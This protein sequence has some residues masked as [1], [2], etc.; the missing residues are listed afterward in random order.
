M[1]KD[2]LGQNA[3]VLAFPLMSAIISVAFFQMGG[4]FSLLFL[5][6]LGAF[7]YGN[8]TKMAWLACA[9]AI[10][11]NALVFLASLMA[12]HDNQVIDWGVFAWK[13]GSV[14]LILLLW[15][16]ITS[17]LPQTHG[18]STANRIV[19]S[20]TAVFILFLLDIFRDYPAFLQH[21]EN[22]VKNALDFTMETGIAEIAF[23]SQDV[24]HVINA[25]ISFI[26]NGAG[27]AVMILFFA[28]NRQVSVLLARLGKPVKTSRL[29][30]YYVEG[31]LVWLLIFALLGAVFFRKTGIPAMEV[32]AWNIATVCLFLYTAQGLGIVS[33]YL[34]KMARSP[35]TRLFQVLLAVIV[36]IS[37]AINL[38][39]CGGLLVL[40]IAENWA[41]LRN[42]DEP[43]CSER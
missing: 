30:D 40:G 25:T 34:S 23:D 26:L 11:G 1:P 19:V 18:F 8:S 37:P 5:V 31:W 39:A 28:V 42:K 29:A 14:A 12:F 24:P 6:P 35:I 43:P 20:G 10:A 27:L 2:G 13:C 16:W 15:T 32:V 17:P 21:M 38:F 9:A 4:F 41:R 33:Y 36:I 3:V 22:I 7:A